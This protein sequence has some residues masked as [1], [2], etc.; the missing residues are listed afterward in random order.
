MGSTQRMPGIGQETP[1]P[2]EMA[3]SWHAFARR[4]PLVGRHRLALTHAD[5]ARPGRRGHR[6]TV[7]PLRPGRRPGD[8]VRLA[9]ESWGRRL[10]VHELRR[11]GR[12]VVAL[13]LVEQRGTCWSWRRWRILHRSTPPELRRVRVD[14]LGRIYRLSVAGL[15][16]RGRSIGRRLRGKWKAYHVLVHG[17]PKPGLRGLASAQA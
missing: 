1:A 9:G 10:V 8:R 12:F 17:T 2:V 3:D 14:P 6:T 5:R 7:R 4:C 13:P 16:L 11:P 15:K